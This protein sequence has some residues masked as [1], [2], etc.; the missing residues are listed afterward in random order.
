MRPCGGCGTT[1][2]GDEQECWRCRA[3]DLRNLARVQRVAYWVAGTVFQ[4]SR[5]PD[6]C[7]TEAEELV[8][9]L[10]LPDAET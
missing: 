7:L 8:R 6:Q 10:G 9:A 2:L 5:A 4:G 1:M 3:R